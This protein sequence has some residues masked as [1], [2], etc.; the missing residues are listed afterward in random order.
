M[1]RDRTT[2][3]II[4][5]VLGGILVVVPW[6]VLAR[7]QPAVETEA[8]LWSIGFFVVSLGVILV[9][10]ASSMRRRLALARRIDSVAERLA[11]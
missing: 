6:V 10:S 4:E 7:R 1:F 2:I 5:Y 8:G 3:W 11:K 9:A